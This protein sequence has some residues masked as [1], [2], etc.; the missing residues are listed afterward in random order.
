MAEGPEGLQKALSEIYV[1]SQ[2]DPQFA[3]S[4][5]FI[6]YQFG[7]QKSLIK[8]A[9]PFYILHYN[10]LG[11]PATE[12]VKKTIL[13]FISQKC[14]EYGQFED[15]SRQDLLER[16]STGFL[17]ADGDKSRVVLSD[18]PMTL[19]YAHKRLDQA[20]LSKAR[21]HFGLFQVAEPKTSDDSIQP[22]STRKNEP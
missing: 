20:S 7:Q 17:A 22:E 13:D 5:H 3:A 9:P 8:V 4:V 19:A 16:N 18:E 10:L 15:V 6:H 21:E 1:Q 12:I 11:R 2:V 14:S